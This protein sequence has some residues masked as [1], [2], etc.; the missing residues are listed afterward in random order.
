MAKYGEPINKT[1]V[2]E[3]NL[4]MYEWRTEK[5]LII[6]YSIINPN[7]KNVYVEY[8]DIQPTLATELKL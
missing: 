4:K 3:A 5:D 1:L 7:A 6:F 2:R 8:K